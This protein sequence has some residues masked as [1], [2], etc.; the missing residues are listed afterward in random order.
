MP[1]RKDHEM[2]II[3]GIA[4]EDHGVVRSPEEHKVTFVFVVPQERTKKTAGTFSGARAQVSLAPRSPHE[5]HG[6]LEFHGFPGV[7]AK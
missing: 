6:S 7:T 5:A 3:V 2:T 4:I 1:V